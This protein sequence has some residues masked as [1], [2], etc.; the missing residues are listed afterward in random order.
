MKEYFYS[1][2][3]YRILLFSY[4]SCGIHYQKPWY[5][6]NNVKCSKE[7]E[8]LLNLRS[9]FVI[10]Y[11]CLCFSLHLC[12]FIFVCVCVFFT[13]IPPIIPLQTFFSPLLKHWLA[14]L[15]LSLSLSV[16]CCYQVSGWRCLLAIP[17]LHKGTNTMRINIF[18]C[19]RKWRDMVG[20]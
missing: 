6:D 20:M 2:M 18:I 5:L 9:S 16:L 4:L 3:R 19:Y 8:C 17:M 11:K 12:G 14:S 13:E 1:F 7:E 15:C 10:C